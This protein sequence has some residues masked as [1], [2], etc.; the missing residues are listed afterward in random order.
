MKHGH[1]LWQELAFL[2]PSTFH[3]ST[4]VT[5]FLLS[6]TL[7]KTDR[8]PLH[9]HI[10][11]LLKEHHTLQPPLLARTQ[12]ITQQ[13]NQMAKNTSATS[14][15]NPPPSVTQDQAPATSTSLQTGSKDSNNPGESFFRE[16]KPI[17]AKHDDPARRLKK[18]GATTAPEHSSCISMRSYSS[19]LLF[20]PHTE[21]QT[22]AFPFREAC[23][24]ITTQGH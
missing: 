1:A 2:F 16:I 14:Q 21:W 23:T 24:A 22:R 20:H 13:G 19:G 7:S 9:L 4:Q 15:H 8:L 17:T 3:P 5:T 10:P 18:H 12:Q 6:S 11:P